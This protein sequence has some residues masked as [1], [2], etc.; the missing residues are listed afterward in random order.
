LKKPSEGKIASAK[1]VWPISAFRVLRELTKN[2]AF[3]F[4]TSVG[5]YTGVTINSP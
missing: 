4:F 1:K 2:E 3:Y 5:D